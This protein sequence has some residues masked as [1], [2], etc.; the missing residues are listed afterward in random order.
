MF[1]DEIDDVRW[2]DTE[3]QRVEIY[4]VTWADYERIASL[5]GESAI[6]R[7]TYCD[8]TLELMSPGQPHEI[9]KTRLARLFEAYLDHLRVAAEGIGSWT[10]KEEN[11]KRGA[12]PDEC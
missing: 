6:P 9:D 8:G 1:D 12:E 2:A 7:L 10:V 4:N 5:R 11:K 3:D